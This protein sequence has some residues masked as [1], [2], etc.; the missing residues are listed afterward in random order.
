MKRIG[1]KLLEA[2]YFLL[3]YGPIPLLI[4]YA[5]V[6]NGFPVLFVSALTVPVAFIISILPATVG[7]KKKETAPIPQRVN[8][9]GDPDPDR[10]LRRDVIVEDK[11]SVSLPLRALVCGILMLGLAVF[12]FFGPISLREEGF[13]PKIV[14]DILLHV[15]TLSRLILS[16]TPVVILPAALRFCVTGASVDTKNAIAGAVI[17]AIAGI[18]ALVI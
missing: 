13:L 2:L 7:G 4:G 3:C 15:D 11:R 17:Y 10:N 18:G 8:S 1:R 16:L 5:V 14:P 6:N 9:G 12:L